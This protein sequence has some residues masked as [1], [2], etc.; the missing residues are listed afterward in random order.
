MQVKK[1]FMKLFPKSLL[2]IIFFTCLILLFV[3]GPTTHSPRSYLNFWDL[4]HLLLFFTGGILFLIDYRKYFKDSFFR[5]LLI[6]FIFSLV[7][8][9]LTELI[10]V[11]FHRDP[12]LG[13]LTRDLIGGFTAV[14]F[15]SPR[16]FDISVIW[17][18]IFKIL[19]TVVLLLEAYP[20]IRSVTDEWIVRRQFPLLSDFETP[21]ELGRWHHEKPLQI[22][23]TI[24]RHGQKS[25]QVHLTTAR[26]STVSLRY[27]PADW[28]GYTHFNF[29]IFNSG[30]DTLIMTCRINDFKHYALGQDY[31]DRYNRLLRLAPGW[32][33][34]SIP[35]TDIVQAPK[36]RKMDIHAMDLICFFSMELSRPR[37]IYI[38]YVYLSI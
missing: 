14:I 18:N 1:G 32:N 17:L 15:F 3:N 10:Q 28:S 11:R 33:D 8:G 4:G 2:Y 26:Y 16:R 25:M 31:Y 29:S 36:A 24:V 38:D 12:D 6:V 23:K 20:F 7:L 27:F 34:C 19:L 21:F 37:V 30:S 22:D 9:L 13:D 5:H 35:V